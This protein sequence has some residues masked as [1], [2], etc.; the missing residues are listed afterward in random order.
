MRL[1][2]NENFPGDAVVA[3]IAA[4]H[5][6]VWVRLDAPGFSDSEV[7]CWAMREDRVLL[8]F[9]KDF[10]ELAWLARRPATCG[11]VLFR[12]PMPSPAGGGLPDATTGPGIFPSSSPGE[13]ECDP[14]PSRSFCGTN[15]EPLP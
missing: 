3:L 7:L 2:A 14:S 1:L 8:A 10:G 13:R 11:V 6:V 9:D 5:D 12:M 15:C 4:G